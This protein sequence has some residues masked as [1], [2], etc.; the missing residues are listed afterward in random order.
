MS[1]LFYTL[2]LF[3]CIV[4]AHANENT[5][6]TNFDI[7]NAWIAEAPPVSKVMVAYLSINNNSAEDISIVRAESAS[8]SSIEFHETIHEHGMAR[9]MRYQQLTVPANGSIELKRSG[10]HL[11]LFNPVK[12]LRAGDTVDISFITRDGRKKTVSVVVKKA[13]Y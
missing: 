12:P 10:K 2:L 8:Y 11:M 13:E 5:A 4:S 6:A 7:R 3:S 9:M 1:R